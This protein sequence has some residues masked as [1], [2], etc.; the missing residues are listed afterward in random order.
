MFESLGKKKQYI[1][2]YKQKRGIKEAYSTSET[3]TK[4]EQIL[5]ALRL[6]SYELKS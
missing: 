6:Q 5:S 3:N 4:T 2:Y 1:H